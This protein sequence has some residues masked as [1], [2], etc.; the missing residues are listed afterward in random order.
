MVAKL[1]LPEPSR[2]PP[3]PPLK[4]SAALCGYL[5][6]L[7]YRVECSRVN[8]LPWT[9]KS[10]L[11]CI[12]KKKVVDS[13]WKINE[14]WN[15]CSV[16]PGRRES[17]TFPARR[18]SDTFPARRESDTFPAR[19]E[20]DTF[21]ARRESDTF[22]A[23]RESDTFPARR[24]DNNISQEERFAWPQKRGGARIAHDRP[25]TA[26]DERKFPR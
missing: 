26:E 13:L 4:I 15:I 9:H 20:A 16:F 2:P 22:P 19:R 7:L 25:H 23:K 24:G 1:I 5:A 6:A 11:I 12:F 21:P 10:A 17:D 8:M 18:E 3:P 14:R